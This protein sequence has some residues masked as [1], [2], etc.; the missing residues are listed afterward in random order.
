MTEA[1][2]LSFVVPAFNEEKLIGACIG[3]IRRAAAT[4]RDFN[5]TA[6]TIV[7]DNNSS[8][9]TAEIAAAAGARVVFEPV[10]QISRARNAG[11]GAAAGDWLIFVDADSEPSA[12]LVGDVAALIE[13]GRYVGCGSTVRMD[14]LPRWARLVLRLQAAASVVFGWAAGSF[15]VCRADAFRA[16][17]GFS[18]ELFASEEIDFCKRLKRWGRNRGLRFRILRGHPLKTSARKLQLYS[19][20]E[21]FRQMLLLTL[22]PR[23][24]ARDRSALDMWYGGRR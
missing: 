8:D 5:V 21:M 2:R 13:S 7:V 3:A 23:R 19:G 1:C 18:E 11:A 22:R 15:I 16:V 24:T 12:G 20:R 17:G 4:L 6:E 9:R 14:G 10:N